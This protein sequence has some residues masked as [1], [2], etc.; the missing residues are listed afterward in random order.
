VLGRRIAVVRGPVLIPRIIPLTGQAE[1]AKTAGRTVGIGGR[2]IG[3][4]VVIP[5]CRAVGVR[6]VILIH[7]V[8]GFG[9]AVRPGGVVVVR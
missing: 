8:I 2:A 6:G 5:A 9:G 4:G 7:G 1:R 3:V